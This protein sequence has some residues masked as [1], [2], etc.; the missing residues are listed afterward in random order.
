[1]RFLLPAFAG[2]CF[3]EIRAFGKRQNRRSEKFKP[4]QY[5]RVRKIIK[6]YFGKELKVA[7]KEEEKE[8]IL[9]LIGYLQSAGGLKKAIWQSAEKQLIKDKILKRG[10][11]MG[12]IESDLP[13][14]FSAS[15]KVTF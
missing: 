12:A 5:S 1:M 13:C 15:V 8:L 3:A 4:D 2:T 9:S 7:T 10:T 14:N 6:D 11:Y